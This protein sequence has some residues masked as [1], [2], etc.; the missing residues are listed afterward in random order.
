VKVIELFAGTGS[1]SKVAKERGHDIFTVEINPDFK[2]DL[3]KDI[4]EVTSQEILESF[5]QPDFIWA[6]P[7]CTTFSVASISR[8]WENGK[9]KNEKTLKGIAIVKKTLQ[10]IKE[11]NPTYWIIENPRGMLRKQDF[12]P[13][14]LRK[15]VTYCQYGSHV[16]KPTDLWTNISFWSPRAMCKPNA[17]CHDHQPR[18]Y[19]SK[20]KKGV[21][22]LGTQGR[23]SNYEKVRNPIFRAIVP[24]ELCLE[25]IQNCEVTAH[26]SQS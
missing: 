18:T 4:L 24:R 5:G 17:D 23:K 2:P 22:H 9:P 26:S 12:M 25:I 7:P 20:K 6:S 10:L 19:A 11:L 15:T 16:Q 14:Q 8:Y 21:L 13:N 3:C 1:F